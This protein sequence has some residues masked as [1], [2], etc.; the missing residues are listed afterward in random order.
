MTGKEEGKKKGHLGNNMTDR[1]EKKKPRDVNF[2][3]EESVKILVN[4]NNY[5]IIIHE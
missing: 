4:N 1:R 5:S 3:L 2:C